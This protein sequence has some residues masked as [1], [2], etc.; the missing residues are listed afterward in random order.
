MKSEQVS[1]TIKKILVPVDLSEASL[2]ALDTAV[3]IAKR[4]GASL[5]IL[6][7]DDNRFDFYLGNENLPQSS[8]NSNDILAALVN[9]IRKAHGFRPEI[10]FDEGNVT[11][12]ILKSAYRE[13]TDLIVTGTHGK[14]GYRDNFIGSTAYN[15]VKYSGCP[16]LLIPPNRKVTLFSNVIFPIRPVPNALSA[17]EIICHFLSP[18]SRL[19][20]FGLAYKVQEKTKLLENLVNE[21]KKQLDPD[22]ISVHTSWLLGNSIAENIL[23]KIIQS[24][25]DLLV[26]TSA[27]DATTKAFFIGPHTQKIINAARIPVLCIKRPGSPSF[28]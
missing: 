14:S 2:Y 8:G 25:P 15:V 28:A 17:Y 3:A 6:S 27:V 11:D 9:S 5:H 1:Y 4:K 7:V 21:I 16:V 10:I 23:D 12:S 24:K 22:N 19:E 18:G 20:I 26:V 13:K